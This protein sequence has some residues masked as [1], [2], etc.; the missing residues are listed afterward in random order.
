MMSISNVV[1]GKLVEREA[2]VASLIVWS[3]SESLLCCPDFLF[4]L[5]WVCLGLWCR[6]RKGMGAEASPISS[7][8]IEDVHVLVVDDCPVDRKIVEKLLLKNGTFKVTTV[9]SGK[10]AMEV[11]G[12]NDE[13]VESPSLNEHKIDIILTD[14]CMPHM[15]GY[16]LLKVVKEHSCLKSVPVVLMSSEND[17]QRI[18]RCRDTGAEDFILKPL[19]IG[20]IQRLTSYVK[21]P[22]PTPKIGVKRKVPPDIVPESNGSER[23]PRLARVAVA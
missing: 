16:N 14:Y 10:K 6:G 9:D 22:T 11:L 2:W 18:S 12:L 8:C 1:V 3:W 4:F 17:P 21:S 13:K 7:P 23:Q 20:D 19:H 5:F 15:N